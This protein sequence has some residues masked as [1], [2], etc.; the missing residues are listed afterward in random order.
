M[1]KTCGISCASGVAFTG[2]VTNCG[3]INLT[4]VTVVDDRTGSLFNLDGSALSQPFNLA[5]AAVVEFMGSFVPSGAETVTATNTITVTG[6]DTTTIGGPNG[7]VTNTVTAICTITPC[8]TCTCPCLI[9]NEST[10]RNRYAL[11]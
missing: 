10:R 3:D 4:N 9:W 5:T 11:K 2:Y 1:F 7:S 6:T 8:T